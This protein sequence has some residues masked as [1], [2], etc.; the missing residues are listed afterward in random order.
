VGITAWSSPRGVAGCNK[1]KM[2]SNDQK[3]LMMDPTLLFNVVNPE[4]F[5]DNTNETVLLN[6]V[7]PDTFHD[8]TNVV[9]FNVV[10]PDKFNDE[11]NVVLFNIVKP[12]I[13]KDDNKV[14][15]LFNGA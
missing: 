3:H 4:I 9:L 5:I 13:F 7:N 1:K 11:P 14:A 2:M 15:F 6:V 8:E 10:K 12:D